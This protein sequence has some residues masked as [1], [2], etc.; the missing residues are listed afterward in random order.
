MTVEYTAGR[1]QFGRPV[2][3]FQAVKHRCAEMM[4]RVEALRS[5]V[6]GAAALAA[7]NFPHTGGLGG[8][9]EDDP[10]PA[11]ILMTA[12]AAPAHPG[13]FPPLRRAECNSC[14]HAQNIAQSVSELK[15]TMH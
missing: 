13:E 2:G 1:K 6:Y 7:G 8:Q 3:G 11:H 12:S 14:G 10:R 15:E 9:P 5:A 4:V